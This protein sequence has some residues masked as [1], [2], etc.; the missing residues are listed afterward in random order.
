MKRGAA[1]A[2]RKL[3]QAGL[4]ASAIMPARTFAGAP[5]RVKLS[6]EFVADGATA[7]DFLAIDRHIYA[8]LGLDVT[9]DASSGSAASIARVAAG[10]HAFGLADASTLIQFACRNP[11]S[12]P[13]IVMP[14]YDVFPGV[15]LSLSRKP[16]A[17]LQDLPRFRLGTG[18]A[19]AGA[20][21]LPALLKLNHIDPASIQRV[22]LDVKL[23]DAMLLK[24]DVDAVVA[25]DYTAVFNLI[26][27]GVKLEDIHLLYYSRS[28]FDF[29]GNAL[30]VNR[31]VAAR[32]PDLVR[33]MALAVA[34]GWVAASGSR[35]AA[36]DAVVARNQLLDTPTELA[37][38]N[39]VYDK[40][41]LTANVRQNGLGAVSTDRIARAIGFIREGLNFSSAP[42]VE[43][44]YDP[45]FMPPAGDRAIA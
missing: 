40:L 9:P 41:I 21:L 5:D 17:S 18:T 2:R 45:R 12:A 20:Q 15:I 4:A 1:M 38:L 31:E 26:G 37:R 16:L 8:D 30:L 39:W 19:D 13:M 32:D 11:D 28:G 33:R 3:M 34:R 6:L 23:R 36:I 22:T 43:A 24:G 7:P 25:F 14:I 42:T 35:A 29:F 10:T 27:N 44:L